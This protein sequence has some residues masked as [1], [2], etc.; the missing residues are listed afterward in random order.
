MDKKKPK[1]EL[2]K[3]S[4]LKDLVVV[5]GAPAAGKSML[6]PIVGSLERTVNFRMSS[7]L[8]HIG[9]MNH[10][11]KLPDDVLVFLYRYIVDF[12]LY[13]NMI[14]RDLNFR[15]GDETSI[16]NTNNPEK[17]WYKNNI[18]IKNKWKW[19]IKNVTGSEQNFVPQNIFGN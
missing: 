19:K 9:T 3:E 13:D 8:E 6:A 2:I 16:F 5:T 15:F 12:M 10:L 4:F 14:G 1:I 18:S 17:Y 11:G 7:V